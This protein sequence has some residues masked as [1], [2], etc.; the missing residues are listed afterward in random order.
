MAGLVV[1]RHLLLAAGEHLFPLR[2]H[3]HL[4]AGVVE[5]GGVD[6]VLVVPRGPEGGLVDE[7]ADVGAR[8]ADGG[9]GKPVEI[10]VG[11]KW[12]VSRVHLEE[13]QA[14]LLVGAID[15]HV[16]VKAARPQERGIEHVGPIG[17]GEHDHTL[18]LA[19]A[20]H[21]GEDLV[22][23]LLSLVV[24]AAEAG[25]ADA[26]HGVDLVHEQDRGRGVFRSLEHVA[27]PRRAHAHEHLDELAARDREEG[28]A[29]LA[30]H[31]PRQERLARARRA[32]QE[33]ALGHA[34][35]EPLKLLR[36]LEK[37]HDLLK[38][39]LHLLESGHVGERHLLVVCGIPLGGRLGEPAEEPGVAER[40]AGL[41]ERHPEPGHQQERHEH[42][43]AHQE[44]GAVGGRLRELLD[45]VVL[46]HE[47]VEALAEVG[48]EIERE[49]L[50]RLA[51]RG[52]LGEFLGE[53]ALEVVAREHDA[54][55]VATLHL[56]HELVVGDRVADRGRIAGEHGGKS[57]GPEDQKNHHRQARASEHGGRVGGSLGARGGI[58]GRGLLR[59]R[60]GPVD[61]WLRSFRQDP[62][63][64][65][66]S[67][68]RCG[69]AVDVSRPT[70]KVE[71]ARCSRTFRQDGQ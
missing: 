13:G 42:V 8:E 45:V 21:L 39:G 23:R 11:G 49:G 22:E 28:H 50:L 43:E 62:L 5:V 53:L 46:L 12:H 1:G 27:H 19:E 30:G 51:A 66:M 10:D 41:P 44:A 17:G 67:A 15:R 2:A 32:H 7:V 16:A 34:A 33:H 18:R 29:R 6:G 64:Y 36:V 58:H 48:V 63:V 25:T 70:E 71:G 57:H 59:G 31:G 54:G 35:A 26:A 40:I 14:G 56:R 47:P 68:A 37:L 38:V 69:V 3:Q 52:R 65:C 55:D 9:A 61:R 4:V 24:A 60:G 20:V